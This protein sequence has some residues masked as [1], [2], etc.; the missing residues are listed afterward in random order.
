[1]SI[2]EEKKKNNPVSSKVII[3]RKDYRIESDMNGQPELSY[4]NARYRPE[5]SASDLMSSYQEKM[6][7]ETEASKPISEHITRYDNFLNQRRKALSAIKD[8]QDLLMEIEHVESKD[9]YLKDVIGLQCRTRDRTLTG[10]H[11]KLS[12]EEFERQ[13]RLAENS[14]FPLFILKDV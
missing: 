2:E 5:A 3:N 4:A 11:T 8:C 6:R 1:M 10:S 7:K 12:K 13:R 14:L 9:P